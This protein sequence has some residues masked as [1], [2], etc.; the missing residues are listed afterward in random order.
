MTFRQKDKEIKK[1]QERESKAD[2]ELRQKNEEIGRLQ[3][4]LKK[5]NSEAKVTQ[6]N[7]IVR[8]L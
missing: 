5:K 8:F 4:E 2:Q 3:K 7:S 6:R 1:L